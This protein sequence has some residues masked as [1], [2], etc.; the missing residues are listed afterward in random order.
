MEV[1]KIIAGLFIFG[2]GL[3]TTLMWRHLET[4]FKY[5]KEQYMQLSDRH[6]KIVVRLTYLENSQHSMETKFLGRFGEIK[7]DMAENKEEVIE[8]MHKMEITLTNNIY[9]IFNGKKTT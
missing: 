7:E 1:Y 9:N 4:K 8:A 5:C 3:Y 6:N 2:M